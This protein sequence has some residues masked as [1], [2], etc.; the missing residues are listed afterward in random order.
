MIEYITVSV[1]LLL[2]TLAMLTVS[3][4]GW[5]L[6][7]T[8]VSSPIVIDLVF[9]FVFIKILLYYLAPTIFRILSDYQFVREDNVDLLDLTFLYMV[10][11]IFWSVWLAAL[12]ITLSVFRKKQSQIGIIQFAALNI[13]EAKIIL[14]LI[15][16][17]FIFINILRFLRIDL[18]FFL[19]VSQSLFSY[20]ALPAGPVLLLL[21]RRYLNNYFFVL[22]LVTT[23]LVFMFVPTRGTLIYTGIISLFFVLFVL[24]SVASKL[25]ISITGFAALSIYFAFGGLF[26][27]S[28]YFDEV[29]NL[30][31][32]TQIESE[33]KGSRSLLGEIEWRY[34]ASTRM[35]TAFINLYERGESAGINPIKHSIMGFL[36]RSINP[37]KP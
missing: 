11:L 5:R 18:N 27:S 20:S 17:G 37:D 16:T 2:L 36:P 30:T 32:D 23:I 31:V 35:G 19:E 34:G 29:G 12:I 4:F 15:C 21:S 9:Y 3:W 24:Q 7:R 14:V 25:I 33:K 8:S 22:G 28:F 26:S 10:E 1:L 13:F 6:S